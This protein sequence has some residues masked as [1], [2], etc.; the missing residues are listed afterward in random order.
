[1]TIDGA[2]TV[3]EFDSGA[4]AGT[5]LTVHW[6]TTAGDDAVTLGGVVGA[7][8]DGAALLVEELP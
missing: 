2:S 6:Q 5:V 8:I 7:G 4:P 1:L 3:F